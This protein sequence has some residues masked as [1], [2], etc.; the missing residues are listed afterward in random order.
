MKILFDIV[1]PADVNFFKCA[2]ASLEKEHDLT[3]WVR[4]RGRLPDIA[5]MEFGRPIQVVGTHACGVWGK[6]GSGISRIAHLS[7]ACRSEGYDVLASFGG[8]YVGIAGKLLRR[9]TVI[10]YDDYEYR[11]NFWLGFLF[12]SQYILPASLKF[13]QRKVVTYQ[14]FK[15]WAY[16][17]NFEPSDEIL[18]DYGICKKQYVFIRHVAPVSLNYRNQ[19]CDQKVFDIVR[20]L[21]ERNI[22]VV[23]SVEDKKNVNPDLAVHF[24]R[25]PCPDIYSLMYHAKCVISS[26]DT[27]AREGA[28]L[29]VPTLYVGERT[30]RVNQPLVQ[31]GLLKQVSA[32]EAIDALNHMLLSDYPHI[33]MPTWDDVTE[34]II[35][36]ILKP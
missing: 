32:D 26:G 29:G 20:F 14:G 17:A 7:R 12:S 5:R 18:V 25:E 33:S 22:Q 10:F 4:N 30:M 2:I 16:L 11:F 9:R 19:K 23:L 31:M 24:V 13:K 27:V 15:E 34:V 28:L 3:I 8:F 6:V 36:Q 35:Q 21:E 1:H